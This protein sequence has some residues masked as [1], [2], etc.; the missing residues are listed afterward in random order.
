MQC[1]YF[2]ACTAEHALHTVAGDSLPLLKRWQKLRETLFQ[3]LVFPVGLVSNLF[4]FLF[5]VSWICTLTVKTRDSVWRV[6]GS[7]SGLVWM[8]TFQWYF[9]F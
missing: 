3:A 1:I 8:K 5:S 4:F 2:S 6:S 9:H 7:I